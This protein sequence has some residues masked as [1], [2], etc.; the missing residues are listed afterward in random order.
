MAVRI[1]LTDLAPTLRCLVG[2]HL[3][4]A[5]ARDHLLRTTARDHPLRTTT[6]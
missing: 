4:R 1:L 2:K 6:P 3:L 5:T